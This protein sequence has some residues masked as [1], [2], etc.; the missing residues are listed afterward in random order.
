MAQMNIKS[1]NV[2]YRRK[3]K[4][5]GGCT[6]HCLIQ[7]QTSHQTCSSYCYHSYQEPQQKF[8]VRR[9]S[10]FSLSTGYSKT[11]K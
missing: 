6:T 11:I 8:G 2:S 9:V 7:L 5:E 10:Q 1:E 3:T 4:M